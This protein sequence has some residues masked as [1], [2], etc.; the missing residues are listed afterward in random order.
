[1]PQATSMSKLTLSGKGSS[2]KTFVDLYLDLSHSLCVCCRQSL[3]SCSWLAI[4]SDIFKTSY[5]DRIFICQDVTKI[6]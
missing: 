6:A 5:Q 1:M 3:S 2:G 4:Y